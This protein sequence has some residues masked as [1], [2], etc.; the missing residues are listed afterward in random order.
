MVKGAFANRRPSV[1]RFRVLP[2][3][4][5]LLLQKPC[6]FQKR[7]RKFVVLSGTVSAQHGH[8]QMSSAFSCLCSV[9]NRIAI[10]TSAISAFSTAASWPLNCPLLLSLSFWTRKNYHHLQQNSTHT[11]YNW[12]KPELGLSSPNAFSNKD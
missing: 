10:S 1:Y 11:G 9:E 6:N 7:C 12:E 2:K 3:T 5:S 4:G 8:V